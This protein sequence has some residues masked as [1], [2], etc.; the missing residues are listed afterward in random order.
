MKL[1]L[2]VIRQAHEDVSVLPV[3]FSELSRTSYKFERVKNKMLRR[4]HRDIVDA[5]L[6]FQDGRL[7]KMMRVAGLDE[8]LDPTTVRCMAA[9]GIK[10]TRQ[11]FR[12]WI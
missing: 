1:V 8:F 11:C 2:A 5:K 6:F 4:I 9:K 12:L 3:R 7:E 10:E